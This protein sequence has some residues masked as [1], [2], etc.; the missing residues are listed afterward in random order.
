V[1]KLTTLVPPVFMYACRETGADEVLTGDLHAKGTYTVHHATVPDVAGAGGGVET[2]S[3]RE[4]HGGGRRSG[5]GSCETWDD[6]E[7]GCAAAAAMDGSYDEEEAGDEGKEW[8]NIVF[9]MESQTTLASIPE[10]EE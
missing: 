8:G 5:E 1:P 2:P 6:A 9:D 3:L 4:H 10:E 7:D